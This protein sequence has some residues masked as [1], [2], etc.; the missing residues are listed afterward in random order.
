MNII[1]LVRP[2]PPVDLRSRLAA[3]IRDRDEA[4]ADEQNAREILIQ[5]QDAL[6]R[7]KEEEQRLWRDLEAAHQSAIQATSRAIAQA[8]RAGQPV[9]PG[10]RGP[11]SS[12]GPLRRLARRG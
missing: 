4:A 8:F 1:P 7:A 2:E 5:A 12:Q 6:A 11:G 9:P 3:A 10:Q